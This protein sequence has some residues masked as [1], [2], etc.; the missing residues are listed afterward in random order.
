[1]GLTV[2]RDEIEQDLVDV[3]RGGL[4]SRSSRRPL[5]DFEQRNNVTCFVF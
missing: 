5:T 4:Y 3:V 1:M 2:G